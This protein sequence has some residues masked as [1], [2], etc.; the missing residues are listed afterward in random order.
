M[1]GKDKKLR[2]LS[3]KSK[4]TIN[5]IIRFLSKEETISKTKKIKRKLMQQK[6]NGSKKS[7]KSNSLKK[8]DMLRIPTI[9]TEP[10]M[11]S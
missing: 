2:N 6:S 5:G 3:F 4:G 7:W 1:K 9:G 8:S 10:R 11:K